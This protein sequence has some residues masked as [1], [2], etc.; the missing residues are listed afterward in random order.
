MVD[1]IVC[2]VHHSVFCF[3]V[4]EGILHAGMDPLLCPSTHYSFSHSKVKHRVVY[5]TRDTATIHTP[6]CQK[7]EITRV[8][9]GTDTTAT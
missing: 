6:K 5:T 8:L 1:I 3:A 9:V 4:A 2:C 7:S